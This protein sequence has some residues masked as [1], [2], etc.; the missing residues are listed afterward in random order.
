M[1]RSTGLR[2]GEFAQRVGVSTDV[3][4]AWERRYGL[5]PPRRSSGN[6]RLYGAEDERIV[7]EVISLRDRGV[8][9]A[10]AVE[11]ARSRWASGQVGEDTP[12][13]DD[14]VD[15]LLRSAHVAVWEFD[16]TATRQAI[17][18]AVESFG[19]QRAIRDVV[20]P[21]LK[22]VG[23][24]WASGRIDVAHEHLASHAVRREIGA[25]GV[26]DP[27]PDAPVVILSCPPGELHDIVLL[28]LGVLLSKRGLSIRF[29]GADTPYS[30][31]QK[32]CEQVKPDLVVVSASRPSVL[33]AHRG[34]IRTISRTWP[35]AIGGRGASLALAEA[36]GATLL[37]THL[38]PALDEIESLARRREEAR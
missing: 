21:L 4:R 23:D 19:A 6:Y 37:P 36:L 12:E 5:L 11:V 31:L 16:E 38:D 3:L 18:A 24:D 14:R 10:E 33:Q 26:L 30:A 35:V 20:I 15:A 13:G 9:I 29:L 32:A 25:A 17:H 28:S 34:A 2:I 22:R 7:R 8:P 1:E 27:D